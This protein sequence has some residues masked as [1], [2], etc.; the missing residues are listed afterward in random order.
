MSATVPQRARAK[1]AWLWVIVVIAGVHATCLAGL[2]TWAAVDTADSARA[3]DRFLALMTDG[4]FAEAHASAADGF[5]AEQDERLFVRIASRLGASGYSLESWKDRTLDRGP[6]TAIGGVLEDRSGEEVRVSIQMV[7]EFA[8]WRVLSVT[9]PSRRGVGPGAWFRLVP[10]DDEVTILVTQTLLDLNQAIKEKDFSRLYEGMSAYF[11]VGKRPGLFQKA[12][13]NFIEDEVDL[14]GVGLVQPVFGS[15][16]RPERSEVAPGDLDILVVE[17]HYPTEPL[18]V[19]F[20]LRFAYEHPEWRPFG[21]FVE[22][23]ET[24]TRDVNDF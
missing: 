11:K 18:P 9:G 10:T 5:R 21:I 24:R 19:W 2:S 23:A 7:R 22:V 17:G 3:A 4:N 6:R 15:A 12:Y 20:V 1:K 14:S 8:E 13:E 16:P